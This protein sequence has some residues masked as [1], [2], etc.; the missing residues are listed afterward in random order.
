MSKN[1][2]DLILSKFLKCSPEELI[3]N[4]R[5]LFEAILK[6]TDERDKYKKEN[7]VLKRKIEYFR[8]TAE[9]DCDEEFEL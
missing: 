4:E 7:E 6:I 5:K 3:G 1:E 2:K 9:R 8:M